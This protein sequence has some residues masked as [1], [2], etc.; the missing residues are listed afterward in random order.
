MLSRIF[1]QRSN[2]WLCYFFFLVFS[3]L[4]FHASANE[5][6]LEFRDY[7][8]NQYFGFD[9]WNFIGAPGSHSGDASHPPKLIYKDQR[10]V[11]DWFEWR[12]GP[13]IKV[14]DA[15]NS[16]CKSPDSC[17]IMALAKTCANNRDTTS[18]S[19]YMEEFC[20]NRGKTH[21]TSQLI[22]KFGINSLI[23][24]CDSI[25]ND[26]SQTPMAY[27]HKEFKEFWTIDIDQNIDAIGISAELRWLPVGD[28]PPQECIVNET[29]T[30]LRKLRISNRENDL[31]QSALQAENAK[32]IEAANKDALVRKVLAMRKSP[33]SA[34]EHFFTVNG[35][36]NIEYY[37]DKKS[38]DRKKNNVTALVLEDYS[39]GNVGYS[40]LTIYE[41][42]CETES[43]R[44]LGTVTFEE[45]IQKEKIFKVQLS[46]NKWLYIERQT[47]LHALYKRF[48]I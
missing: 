45:P 4:Y 21:T 11:Q 41:I 10:L 15:R 7:Q 48:C 39:S 42:N 46:N 31:R 43:S 32:K 26:P 12:H 16:S 18:K 33:W 27:Y 36:P 23:E 28:D 22:S 29:T 44:W 9:N 34:F 35:N 47:E 1:D 38:I 40:D 37:F 5:K 3:C 13:N 17:P 25:G 6:K 19:A 14:F 30:R 20:W 2:K 24:V 8:T